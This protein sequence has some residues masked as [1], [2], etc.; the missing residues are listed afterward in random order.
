MNGD[1]RSYLAAAHAAIAPKRGAGETSI[2]H[3]G[4]IGAGLMGSGI[5][6]SC[7]QAGLD[8]TIVDLSAS[9]LQRSR[10]MISGM[11]EE[12]VKRGKLPGSVTA[13]LG[14]TFHLAEDYEALRSCDLVI[15][16]VFERMDIKQDVFRK[17]SK[18]VRTG[19]IVASNT[20]GLDIDAIAVAFDRPGD[21]V[22]LHFFSP[23]HIMPLLEIIRGTQT[24]PAT[25]AAASAFAGLIGKTG[26]I[27]G[28]CF[29]FAANRSLNG[30]SR[31]AGFLMLE[32][33]SPE[34]IDGVLTEF[35]FPMGPCAMGDLAGLDIGLHVTDAMRSEGLTPDDPRL[36]SIGR[37][38]VSA[39][40]LGQK[41]GAGL[42]DYGKDR[43]KPI[44]SARAAEIIDEVRK[45]LEIKTRDI[46]PSEIL[47]RCLLPVINEA[48]RILSEG[49]VERASDVDL[50]WIYGY[51]YP[52]TRGGPLFYANSLGL[53]SLV[54][55]L[56][57]YESVQP[58][59]PQY[60]KPAEYLRSLAERGD[61]F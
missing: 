21:V 60:W 32:G 10:E 11:L 9:T 35:G 5:A 27:V 2:K 8:V 18:Y 20:S 14:N 23:A 22:G 34:A 42:F 55:R 26:I 25:L 31:E 48:A 51:G 56:E 54:G 16:A 36:A 45:S 29:G 49:I 39:G 44:A 57:Y 30:Y 33:A 46:P 28:N 3:V 24:S 12:G 1:V 40:R 52:S 38:M 59:G 15:E 41:A 47:E 17:L 50:I 43:R 4:I 7:L 6:M 61:A 58:F 19:A 37:A 53:Q 13:E